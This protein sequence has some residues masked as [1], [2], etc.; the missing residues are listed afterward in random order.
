MPK[1]FRSFVAFALDKLELKGRLRQSVLDLIDSAYSE[2]YKLGYQRGYQ[3]G[4]E[5]GRQRQKRGNGVASH[6]CGGVPLPP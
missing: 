3:H 2:G 4:V 6:Y 5:S 1:H